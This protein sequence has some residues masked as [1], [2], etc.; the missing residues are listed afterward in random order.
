[1]P[2]SLKLVQADAT[3]LQQTLV[4]LLDN[5]AKYAPHG[6]LI[7]IDAEAEEATVTLRI[8][9]GGPGLPDSELDRVF[10]KFFR[11][12]TTSARH[13]GTGLG[14]TICRGLVEAMHGTIRASN[15]VDRS[16]LCVS[17]TLPAAHAN[18]PSPLAD[19]PRLPAIPGARY[20]R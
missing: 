13:P 18:P 4:N 1:V 11:S 8:V 3:L 20:S 19:L 16:G 9:D 2:D 10:D 7:S 12:A 15:R 14:L 6:S 17:I 5:A